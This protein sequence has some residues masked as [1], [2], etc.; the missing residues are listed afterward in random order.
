M[1]E[2]NLEVTRDFFDLWMRLYEASYGRMLEVP[3]IGPARERI[4]KMRHSTDVA[5][6]LYSSWVESMASFQSVFLEAM[7]RTREK[8]AEQTTAEGEKPASYREFYELWMNTYSDTFKEFLKS[9]YFAED[10]HRLTS[11]S[12]DYQR[13]NRDLLEENFLKPMNLPTRSEIDEINKEVYL[14]KKTN[15]ELMKRL[16]QLEKPA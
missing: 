10:L 15:K 5:V 12:M 9:G 11:N 3:A 13:S 4:E 16:E 1:Q 6:N 8:V 14:L 7:R 2:S